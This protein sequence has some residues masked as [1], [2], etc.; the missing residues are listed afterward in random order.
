MV[1]IGERVLVLGCAGAGKTVFARR[2]AQSTGLPLVTLDQEYWQ[3]G[4]VEPDKPH[5]VAKVETLIAAPR[6]IMD[7]TYLGTLPLRLAR[8]D[9]VIFLDLPRWVC[10]W[11]AITR[12]LRNFGRTRDDM[13]PGC[14]ER[15]DW[16]FLTYIWSFPSTHRPRVVEALHGFP[17]ALT[18]C[19]NS[20][21]AGSCLA[22][23]E[24][25]R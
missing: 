23:C 12:I 4:W 21:D 1:A 15:F 6:W 10:L 11:R 22:A 16:K 9:T 24:R 8:A 19:R 14:P 7:G 25:K 17:G 13:A 2:L 5:W 3:P 20:R 18:V